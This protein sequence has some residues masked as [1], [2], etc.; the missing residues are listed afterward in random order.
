[1]SAGDVL[2]R[3]RVGLMVWVVVAVVGIGSIGSEVLGA[4]AAMVLLVVGAMPVVG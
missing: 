3:S 2:A 1:M 4:E